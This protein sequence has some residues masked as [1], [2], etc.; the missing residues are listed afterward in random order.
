M[1][2]IVTSQTGRESHALIDKDSGV[3]E[4]K[5]GEISH[6]FFEKTM[7]MSIRVLKD[8]KEETLFPQ[9]SIKQSAERPAKKTKSK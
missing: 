1:K 9:A 3:I 6:I 8:V 4:Y 2:V 7:G 5:D